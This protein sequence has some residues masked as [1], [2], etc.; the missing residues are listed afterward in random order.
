MSFFN[1]HFYVGMLAGAIALVVVGTLGMV[2]LAAVIAHSMGGGTGPGSMPAVGGLLV[3]PF[4]SESDPIMG[5][6][7]KDLDGNEIDLAE[8]SEKVVFVN[9]WATWCAPCIM[10]MP[11]I[12]KLAGE[13]ANEDIAF[14]IV[15][16]EPV[17]TV[18]PFVEDKDWK[19]PVYV[20]KRVPPVF[21]TGGIPSTFILDGERRVLFAH[22][23][24][25]TWDAPASFTYFDRLLRQPPEGP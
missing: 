2:A 5:W 17:D 21:Q 6:P 7:L 10:E 4:P 25:A 20:T 23:G 19:V 1:K 24:S 12:E 8:V 11:S 9:M 16:R 3:P 18:A 22:V 15:S 14:L 13:L